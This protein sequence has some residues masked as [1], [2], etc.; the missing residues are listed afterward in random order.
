[1][2]IGL[3]VHS[4]GFWGRT[5]FLVGVLAFG[6]GCDPGEEQGKEI[7]RVNHRTISAEE[8]EAFLK[9]KRISRKKGV[10]GDAVLDTYLEREAVAGIIEKEGLLD[11]ALI[12][13][14]LSEFKKEMLI[15]RYFEKF[16]ADKVTDSAVAAY[17][18]AHPGEFEERRVHV[19]HV[20]VRTSKRMEENERAAKRTK[21]DEAYG[22]LGSGE[23]FASVVAS[24]SE[25]KSSLEKGG[26]LG[27]IKEGAF[28]PKFSEVAF[29]LKKEEVS[30]PIETAFGFHIVTVIE[31]PK[32]VKKPLRAVS[33]DIRYRLREKAKQAE[34]ARLKAK[35]T[36]EKFS[37]G[38]KGASS[39]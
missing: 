2:R 32:V 12:Q 19:A 30:K 33:G 18:E 26:D 7:A 14:E 16:L 35:A 38:K 25:D 8:F 9:L 17:Y 3:C 20:L 1:M 10:D 37:S 13:A 4:K 27:W 31:E 23:E 29:S 5:V 39:K 21:A 28:D 24:Y 34:M 6:M 36:I 22:K 11:N 15:S